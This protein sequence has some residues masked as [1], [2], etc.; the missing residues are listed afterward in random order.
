MRTQLLIAFPALLICGAASA[1]TTLPSIEVR[2]GTNES[3]MVSCKKPDSVS[4]E[5]VERV[6]SIEDSSMTRAIQK[7]FVA[8]VSE[9]CKAGVAHILVK[10]DSTGTV[11]W[12]RME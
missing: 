11:T 3:V 2:A 6:L 9:A 4:R 8:A 10:S 12:K 7:R 1:Q 5:D